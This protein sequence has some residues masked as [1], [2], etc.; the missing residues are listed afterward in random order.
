MHTPTS[1]AWQQGSARGTRIQVPTSRGPPR[2]VPRPSRT[3][4]PPSRST[5]A[6]R[7]RGALGSG[8]G[9]CSPAS[10]QARRI[11]SAST[12]DAVPDLRLLGPG[13]E[14]ALDAFL[15]RHAYSLMFLRS[16]ARTVGLLDTGARIPPSY[17]R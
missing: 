2:H 5:T 7:W 13:D 10:L 15:A 6:R 3:T 17:V 11:S 14:A 12:I 9:A 8:P 16:N 4:G 1:S